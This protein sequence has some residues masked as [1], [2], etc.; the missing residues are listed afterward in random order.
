MTLNNYFSTTLKMIGLMGFQM[1][2]QVSAASQGPQKAVRSIPA[3]QQLS[4]FTYRM[5]EN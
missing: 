5:G 3:L 1:S 4:S 2:Y